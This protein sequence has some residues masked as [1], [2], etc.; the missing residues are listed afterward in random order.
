MSTTEVIKVLFTLRKLIPTEKLTG[1]RGFGLPISKWSCRLNYVRTKLLKA[2]LILNYILEV[3]TNRGRP[4]H[5]C[6][7]LHRP[8]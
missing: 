7:G 4:W 5:G 6:H 3:Y 1:S 2:F 8:S